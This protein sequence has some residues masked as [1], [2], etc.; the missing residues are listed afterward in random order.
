MCAHPKHRCS[1]RFLIGVRVAP[2]FFSFLYSLFITCA[3]PCLLFSF[4]CVVLSFSAVLLIML[5]YLLTLPSK[6][7][8][9][10]WLLP[11]LTISSTPRN[12]LLFASAGLIIS[13]FC[14]G[15]VMK[16]FIL[17][18]DE[19]TQTGYICL[20][21]ILFLIFQMTYVVRTIKIENKIHKSENDISSKQTIRLHKSKD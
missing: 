21:L 8:K 2:L 11:E 20:Y 19:G 3:C 5:L 16:I 7:L 13:P 1:S 6:W 17:F 18:Y 12:C 10:S 15:F 4:L 14:F 9:E